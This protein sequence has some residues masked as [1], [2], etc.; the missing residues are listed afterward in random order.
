M[1]H[2]CKFVCL[3][4]VQADIERLGRPAVGRNLNALEELSA[5]LGASDA[6]RREG[7]PRLQ[8]HLLERI[9]NTLGITAAQLGDLPAAS[10]AVQ[11]AIDPARQGEL[12]LTQQ[13]RD[14]VEAFVKIQDPQ[15]RLR[16]LQV[17]LEASS[18]K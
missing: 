6:D 3:G 14:L 8:Q 5:A 12:I 2:E 17:V 18:T 15:D 1:V 7:R 4:M 13:C 9:A 16:C 11:P 10:S